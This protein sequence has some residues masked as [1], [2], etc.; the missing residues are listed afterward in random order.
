MTQ[1]HTHKLK[2]HRYKTGNT[3]YFC[4]L[5]D[6]HWKLECH[7]CLG[8]K[9]ICNLCGEEF[10]MTEYTIKLARPHC[11]NCSKIKVNS[12]DGKKRYV[13][14]D[15]TPVMAA[16]ANENAEDLRS[17]LNDALTSSSEEDI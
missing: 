11:D 15:S 9:A 7:L 17:R 10:I 13:R 4:T 14:K 6:C 5:P 12:P 2:R 16:L 3:V 8:K 1:K